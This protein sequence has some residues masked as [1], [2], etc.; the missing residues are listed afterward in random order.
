MVHQ[1][2]TIPRTDG[3]IISM[4]MMHL[5]VEAGVGTDREGDMEGLEVGMRIG[6]GGVSIPM[7][8]A[9]EISTTIQEVVVVPMA[10]EDAV[11]NLERLE[12]DPVIARSIAA[13]SVMCTGLLLPRVT[14][15]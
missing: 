1:W 11:A 14:P 4:Q 5:A 15:P 3:S 7:P 12:C 9:E 10:Q 8:V 6:P 13:A 2:T